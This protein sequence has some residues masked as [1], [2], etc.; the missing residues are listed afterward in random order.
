MDMRIALTGFG[1]VGQ[2]LATLI[3]DSGHEYQ[4][5]YGLD[6]LL[7]GVADRTGAAVDPA[8]LDPERLLRAKA[9]SGT[10]AAYPGGVLGMSGASMLDSA[11]ALV[12]VEAA[13]TNFEDAQP[14]WGYILSALSHDM[15]LVLASKGA[16]VL[17]YRRLNE[18]ARA[19]GRR[20]LM[21]G[22]TGA[23]LPVIETCSRILVGVRVES[24]EGIVNGTTNVILTEMAGGLSYEEGVRAAQVAGVAETDPTLDVDGWDAAAKAV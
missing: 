18:E 17:H 13:S 22:T 7:T 15:D 19:R 10:V 6:L 11:Q 14:G 16:L 5:R 1:N 21:A 23:P 3:R 20:V 4:E 9:E 24:F 8:G 12:L 2:G